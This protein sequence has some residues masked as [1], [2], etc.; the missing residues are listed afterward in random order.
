MSLKDICLRMNGAFGWGRETRTCWI[1][2]FLSL[3]ILD[4]LPSLSSPSIRK[5]LEGSH[6]LESGLEAVPES[7]FELDLLIILRGWARLSLCLLV[8]LLNDCEGVLYVPV[9]GT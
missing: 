8:H 5:A 7:E 6:G 2:N 9:H 4:P 3:F 1:A